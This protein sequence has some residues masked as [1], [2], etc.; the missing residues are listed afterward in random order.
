MWAHKAPIKNIPHIPNQLLAKDD[1]SQP[2]ATTKI[3]DHPSMVFW[4]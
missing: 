3:I 1:T 4:A 2:T